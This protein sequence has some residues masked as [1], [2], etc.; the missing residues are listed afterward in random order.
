M[1]HDDRPLMN[2]RPKCTFDQVFDILLLEPE[3]KTTLHTTGKP[4]VDFVAGATFTEQGQ[5]YVSVPHG[6]RIYPCCWGNS[7][8]HM[9]AAGKRGQRIGQYSRPLDEWATDKMR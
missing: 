7:E 3:R 4:G 2:P 5:R 9:G 1:P 6:N 8:N